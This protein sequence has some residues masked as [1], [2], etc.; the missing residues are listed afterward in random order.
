MLV[1]A[2]LKMEITESAQGYL[3]EL[4][5]KQTVTGM[6]V[7]IY[8]E[9]PGTPRAE[10]CM[11]YCAEGE[12]EADD[13]VKEYPEFR[14]YIEGRSLP[15]LEDSLVDYSKDRMGGQLTFRAPRSK[16]PNLGPNASIEEQINHVLYAEVNPGLAAHG[17]NVSLVEV[18]EDATQ[19]LTAVLR[20]GG[21]CQGCSAVDM[22]L[23]DGVQTTLCE[24]IPELK[25]VTDTTDHSVREHAYYR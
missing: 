20:F 25:R 8:V 19:G 7:R 3:K 2:D 22:T 23:R 4:L 16:V 17:G 11:A 9:N 5:S 15:Y 12:Q 24:R 18:F 21:G 10:C 6:G 14:A 13:V 1:N